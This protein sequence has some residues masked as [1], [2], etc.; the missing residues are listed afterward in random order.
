[1]LILSLLA[2]LGRVTAL[3]RRMPMTSPFAW[4]KDGPPTAK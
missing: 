3:A 4:R 2:A 1:M